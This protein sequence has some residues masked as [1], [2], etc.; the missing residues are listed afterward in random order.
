MEKFPAYS[1]QLYVSDN[2]ENFRTVTR[3]KWTITTHG[4]MR[5]EEKENKS[6]DKSPE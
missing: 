4:S 5:N 1:D 2:L 6:Q 3:L